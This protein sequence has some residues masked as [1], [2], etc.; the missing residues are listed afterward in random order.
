MNWISQ[1]SFPIIHTNLYPSISSNPIKCQAMCHKVVC[2]P[3][4]CS[5]CKWRKS[6]VGSPQN[7]IHLAA[8]TFREFPLWNLTS[9]SLGAMPGPRQKGL[10][11]QPMG[12]Q[13]PTLI[14]GH[15]P[16]QTPSEAPQS[17]SED[18]NFRLQL[19]GA[20]GSWGF[21]LH[22]VNFANL[23]K[24]PDFLGLFSELKI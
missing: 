24:P 2:L 6:R 21:R 14:Y 16:S 19:L 18:G 9:R 11:I 15:I 22:W 3:T 12:F 20:R 7:P 10:M 5:L 4:F 13:I 8:Q 17:A 23:G 1:T